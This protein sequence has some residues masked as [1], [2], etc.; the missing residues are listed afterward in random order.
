[1]ISNNA[2][3]PEP[4][5]LAMVTAFFTNDDASHQLVQ[6][7][8]SH[9]SSRAR[10]LALRA[11]RH[12]DWLSEDDWHRA[13]RDP[14]PEVRR[15]AAALLSP[16]GSLTPSIQEDLLALLH[17][18][19]ALVV[20]MSAFVTG[21]LM[22]SGAVEELVRVATVHEDARCRESA[23]AA[24]GV[25]GDDRGRAAIVAA[26]NDKPPIRRRAIV[27]LANFEGPDIDAALNAAK[28]DRDWQ[29]RAAVDQLERLPFVDD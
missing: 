26:L 12:H 6:E 16:S 28:D 7:T 13:L 2:T 23:V 14:S 1:M 4:L 25:L 18:D 10:L 5:R 22:V 11:A 15:E 29:V 17:D 9:P 3:L 21:E 19:D 24:L 27:S 8:L 20:E